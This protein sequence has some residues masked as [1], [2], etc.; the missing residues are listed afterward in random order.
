MSRRILIVGDVMV[1]E[2]VFVRTDRTA[3]EAPIP[4]WDEVRRERRLGG[5]ANVLRNVQSISDGIAGIDFVGC[6]SYAVT[7]MLDEI[8]GEAYVSIRNKPIVK[9]RFVTEDPWKIL[10]R[11]D[12]G[13]EPLSSME[14][15]G[16]LENISDLFSERSYDLIVVSDYD[17]GTVTAD[18]ARNLIRRGVPV[19]VDSKR[20]D[21]SVF[22]GAAYM[23]LNREE[24]RR[25]NGRSIERDFPYVIETLGK[26]GARLWTRDTSSGHVSN[27]GSVATS[28]VVHV[29][30]F[31][32][33]SAEEIDVTGCGDVH[34]AAM[35]LSLVDDPSDVRSAVR[36]AN[37]AAA[38][39]VEKQGTVGV[40]R[41]DLKRFEI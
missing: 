36:I 22:H 5:A 33:N 1:D 41:W 4:V 11:H 34:T 28:Y 26:D 25:Q 3:Q 38:A 30:T 2:Y 29:E 21:L 12:R 37:V 8:V 9:T 14:E 19:L 7:E 40:T 31:P 15:I 13:A 27:Y 23:K 24:F 32:G 17:K 35:A 39:A 6:T 20:D 18:V 16:I 10:F